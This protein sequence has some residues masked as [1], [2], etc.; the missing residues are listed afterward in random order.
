MKPYTE[1]GH[2]CTLAVAEVLTCVQTAVYDLT[3]LLSNV[4]FL[5]VVLSCFCWL[6]QGNS[7]SLELNTFCLVNEIFFNSSL[8]VSCQVM[9]V[10]GA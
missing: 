5:I 6:S 9:I 2:L 10:A 7:Q 3:W 1:L 4:F 8:L